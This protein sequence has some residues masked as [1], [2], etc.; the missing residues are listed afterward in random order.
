MST[1]TTATV[2][3]G[4]CAATA[5]TQSASAVSPRHPIPGSEPKWLPSATSA[6][7]T[8]SAEKVSFGLLL[9]LRNASAAESTLA[10]ISDPSSSSYGDYLSNAEFNATFAPSAGDVSAV[11]KWLKGQG[12]TLGTSFQSGMYVSATGTTAQ[13]EKTFG[14]SLKNYTVDGGQVHANTT[15][16]SLPADAPE[17]VVAAVDGVVG[18]DQAISRKTPS[19]STSSS[20]NDVT[21]ANYSHN[22]SSNKKHKPA[23]L[24][25]RTTLPGPPD[26][27][28]AAQPCSSYFGQKI[29]T[30]LPS[31]YGKKQPYVVCGY[32][33]SQMQSAY[34]LDGLIN[35]GVDGSGITVA[36]TDAFAAPTIVGDMA[37]YNRANGL[38]QFSR[39]QFSQILPSNDEYDPDLIDLCDAQGWYGEE[40][41]DIQAVHTMAPGAKIVYV[42]GADCVTGL[43]EAWATTIDDHVADVITNSWTDYYDD[44][45]L[46]PAD[47][48]DFYNQFS[49]EAAL[50]GISVLFSTGDAG[51]HTLTPP[52]G[53]PADTAKSVEFP[54]DVPWVT[55]VGGT[56]VEIGKQGN[57]VAEYGWQSAYSD[58]ID[59]P[60]QS[61]GTL[62]G[63]W[64]AGGG[65]GTSQL[66][67]QPFYQTAAVPSSVSTWSPT[68]AGPKMRAVPDV[69][70]PADPNTGLLVGETQVFPDGTYYDQYRI[71]GTSLASPLM[72]GVLAVTGDYAH[73]PVGFANPMLYSLVGTSKV[74]D[75]KA[76]NAPVAQIRDN[77]ANSVDASD[78]VTYMVQTIDVQFTTLHD[79]AG[80]DTET[81]VGTPNGLAFVKGVAGI[82]VGHRPHH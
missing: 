40:T 52:T 68:G 20:T 59:G 17:A 11:K 22:G 26:G 49:L 35:S 53:D 6:G 66:F 62:P 21:V 69:A 54:A 73:H 31:A 57:Y 37:K 74:H 1:L 7:D 77:Y 46:I 65:G 19:S 58:T 61:F 76:P 24:L 44:P 78:G 2:V 71:G 80:W 60:G 41:L 82:P 47:Y 30:S 28:R 56:S 14:T 4:A 70:M 33:P 25:G 3:L 36:V 10:A 5:F 48:A 9:G 79:V 50:T 43:D 8:P 45:A 16:L 63:T 18:L 67:S 13:V 51:D 23:P 81:G 64:R 55:G 38:P 12:F 34:G 39:G 32:T 75:V 72:A 29:A 27:V 42:G 15:Q